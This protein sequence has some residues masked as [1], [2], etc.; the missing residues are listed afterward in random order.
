MHK[1][2]PQIE[3]KYRSAASLEGYFFK[4]GE[5]AL[6]FENRGSLATDKNG[7]LDDPETRLHIEQ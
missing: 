3:Q 1:N 2:E 6:S 7:T 5:H 4:D